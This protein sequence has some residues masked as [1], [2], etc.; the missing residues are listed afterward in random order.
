MAVKSGSMSLVISIYWKLSTYNYLVQSASTESWLH[1]TCTDIHVSLPRSSDDDLSSGCM[2]QCLYLNVCSIYPKY[3]DLAA[4]L[5]A[6][7]FDIAAITETC[8]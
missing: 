5:V 3:S 8:L 7:N 1:A 4:L 6:L 2:L